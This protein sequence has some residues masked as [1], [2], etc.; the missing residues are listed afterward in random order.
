ML[1]E[2]VKVMRPLAWMAPPTRASPVPPTR[3]ES[4]EASRTLA[5]QAAEGSL[6]PEDIN[7]EMFSRHLWTAGLP[8]PELLIRTGGDYR[9]SNFMLWQ[10][11]RLAQQ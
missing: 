2:L 1:P 5:R 6:K 8:D 4:V 11:R 7:E 9:V 10:N 3:M